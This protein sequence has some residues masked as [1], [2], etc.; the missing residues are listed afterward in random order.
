MKRENPAWRDETGT[1][2]PYDYSPM[3]EK[4]AEIA[5]GYDYEFQHDPTDNRTIEE[6]VDD[7]V[8]IAGNHDAAARDFLRR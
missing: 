7:I 5:C 1:T 8:R 3:S 2:V 4:E 6:M